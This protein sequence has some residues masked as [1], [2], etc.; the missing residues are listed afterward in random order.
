MYPLCFVENFVF[1]IQLN[2]VQWY[3]SRI[4]Y[5]KEQFPVISK[6]YGTNE[7]Y[8]PLFLSE[9][10]IDVLIGSETH[11][12]KDILNSE[13]LPSNY[14]ATR[15]D[16]DDGF[17][18]IAIIYK[19]NIMVED[20]HFENCELVAIKIE[21]HKKHKKPIVVCACYS[22]PNCDNSINVEIINN[23]SRLCKKYKNNPI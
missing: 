13:I 15:K 2:I 6:A 9:N 12:T 23:I 3:I 22:P 21:T 16:R 14:I 10:D 7:Q 20:I 1:Y 18:G 17:G 5:K 4:N 8:Y 11:L 19:N